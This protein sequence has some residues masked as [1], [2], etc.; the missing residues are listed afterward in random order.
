MTWI[1]NLPADDRAA[2][3]DAGR[4]GAARFDGPTVQ[5]RPT[6]LFPTID[7]LSELDAYL[8]KRIADFSI[9]VDDDEEAAHIG[10]D[11]QQRSRGRLAML[12]EIRL[13]IREAVESEAADK[14]A[15]AEYDR[16]KE[17]GYTGHP[18]MALVERERDADR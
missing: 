4:I 16:W 18:D 2:L 6:P 1:D 13:V 10:W 7:S 11:A 17:A 15:A 3:R 5:P 12:S 14:A 8:L 9:D